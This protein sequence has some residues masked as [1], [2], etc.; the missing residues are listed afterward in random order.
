MKRIFAGKEIF[1]ASNAAENFLRERGFSF[2]STQVGG[3]QAI[4]FG[5][6]IVSKWRNLNKKERAAV[7]GVITGDIRNGPVEVDIYDSAPDE[8]IT[9][10]AKD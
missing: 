7:H 6:R 3:P 1:E 9:A 10:F 8:A 4:L 5:D 2:G